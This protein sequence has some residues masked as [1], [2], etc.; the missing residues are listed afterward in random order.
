MAGNR[1][2][3]IT[4]GEQLMLR[5]SVGATGVDLMWKH[6]SNALPP[7]LA[8]REIP[9]EVTLDIPAVMFTQHGQYSCL[10]VDNQNRTHLVLTTEVTVYG[11]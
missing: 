10:A 9:S 6:T 5:C 8:V 3:S 7:Q 11:E 1:S 2:I 4:A